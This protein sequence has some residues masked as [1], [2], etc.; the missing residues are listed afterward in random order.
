MRGASR[1]SGSRGSG[2]ARTSSVRA[3]SSTVRV[4]G[5]MWAS[6]P[7]APDGVAGMRP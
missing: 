7:N 2:R 1:A 3:A 4:S 6:L 5:P